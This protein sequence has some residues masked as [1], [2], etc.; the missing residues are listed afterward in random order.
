MGQRGQH[1]QPRPGNGRLGFDRVRQ[2]QA[3][4][5][6]HLHIQ[7]G[8]IIRVSGGGLATQNHERF[9]PAPGAVVAHP[10]RRHLMMYDLPIGLVVVHDQHA[11]PVKT[12][13]RGRGGDVSSLLLLEPRREPEGGALAGRALDADLP[14]HVFDELLRDG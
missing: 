2:R 9:G 10:P 12:G 5:L 3:V 7:N 8:Y 11:H 13:L 14:A 1:Y 6:R 4:H